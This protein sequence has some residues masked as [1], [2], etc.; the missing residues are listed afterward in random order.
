MH[1]NV[2]SPEMMTPGRYSPF[3]LDPPEYG[4]DV[5]SV[6]APSRREAI[7]R[8]TPLLKGWCRDARSDGC[9]PF[10]GVT[11]EDPRCPHGVCFCELCDS[12]CEACDADAVEELRLG[13]GG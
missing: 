1:W 12:E 3:G 13:E 4:C 6:E 11:A 2:I 9:N 7:R 5:V 8:G 10:V